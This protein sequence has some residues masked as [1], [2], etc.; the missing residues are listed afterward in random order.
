MKLIFESNKEGFAN[1]FIPLAPDYFFECVYPNIL[2]THHFLI[3][4]YLHNATGMHKLISNDDQLPHT[5][6]QKNTVWTSV[7]KE[8]IS[9][10]LIYFES[11][12]ANTVGINLWLRLYQTNFCTSSLTLPDV[13]SKTCM[14]TRMYHAQYS[15]YIQINEKMKNKTTKKYFTRGATHIQTTT[16]TF[17]I[18]ESN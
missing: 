9:E 6:N 14:V 2:R 10:V 17:L 16:V 3:I 7:L 18:A 4:L 8:S 13:P 12:V 15:E 11:D 5:C 1:I